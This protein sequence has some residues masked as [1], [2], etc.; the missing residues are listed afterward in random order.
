MADEIADREVVRRLEQVVVVVDR[1][2]I[3]PVVVL[4]GP[5]TVGKSTLLRRLAARLDGQLVDLD[6]RAART[7][8]TADPS[9]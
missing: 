5:R 4:H 9:L 7:V 2:A 8:A 1:L 3:S 6:E